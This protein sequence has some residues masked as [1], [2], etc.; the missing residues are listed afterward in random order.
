MNKSDLLQRTVAKMER[1]QQKKKEIVAYIEKN[2]P[3]L[4]WSKDKQHRIKECCNV[5][6]FRD[7]MNWEQKLY[8]SNFCKY[9]KFCLACST[10]RSIKMIQRFMQWIEQ[11]QLYNKHRYHITLTVKHNKNQSL[12]TVLNKLCLAKEKLWKRYRNWKR[13]SQKNKSF[14]NNF[15]WIV[16]SIEVTYNERNWRHPHI[17]MLVCWDKEI[18]TETIYPWWKEAHVNKELQKER[19]KITWDSYQLSIRKV[20]VDNGYFDRSWIWEV[21]KYAVKFSTLDT[22]H[23]VELVELQHNRK[24]HFF[25]TYWIFRGR[26]LDKNNTKEDSNY[27]VEKTLEYFEDD[28]EYQTQEIEIYDKKEIIAL[29]NKNRIALWN[30][31]KQF[32]TVSF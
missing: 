22:P 23:L 5:L 24:Y 28:E 27:Y 30:I 2:K 16:S 11:Y 9:D 6:K 32:E 19:Y 3:F 21:F 1:S 26:K 14:M 13:D 17:H 10:R 8:K 31:V 12:K 25:S 18:Q 20:K 7:Y 29:Q 15:D 4:L